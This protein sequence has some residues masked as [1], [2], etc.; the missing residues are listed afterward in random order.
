MENVVLAPE[1]AR[2]N[3]AWRANIFTGKIPRRGSFER[4]LNIKCRAQR[5]DDFCHRRVVCL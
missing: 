5:G 2:Q 3:L 1:K 4:H